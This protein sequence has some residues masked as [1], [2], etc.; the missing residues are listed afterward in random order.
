MNHMVSKKDELIFEKVKDMY[1]KIYG[2]Y[3]EQEVFDAYL[4]VNDI[5]KKQVMKLMKEQVKDIC[6]EQYSGFRNSIGR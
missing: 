3:N 5:L 2:S 6:D 4:I 1:F